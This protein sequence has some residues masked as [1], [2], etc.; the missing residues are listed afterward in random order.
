MRELFY[1]IS[2][3]PTLSQRERAGVKTK[4]K[5]IKVQITPGFSRTHPSRVWFTEM[6]FRELES[7]YR[8]GGRRPYSPRS[9]LGLVLYGVMQGVTSLREL[10]RLARVNLGCMWASGGITPDH[11]VIGRF[12]TQHESQLSESQVSS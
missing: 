9:M 10:E 11:S 5:P 3:H 1:T 4:G 12:L 2:P 7:G 6:D 8:P